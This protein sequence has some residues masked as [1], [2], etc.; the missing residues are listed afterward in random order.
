MEWRR[1]ASDF[2]ESVHHVALYFHVPLA[3]L[4]LGYNCP[5]VR[6]IASR[7]HAVSTR[8][9]PHSAAAVIARRQNSLGLPLNTLR[10]GRRADAA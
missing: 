5:F 3:I 10:P 8:R 1:A 9:S 7:M 4:L 2:G 6:P